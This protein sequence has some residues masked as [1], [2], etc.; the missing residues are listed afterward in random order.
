MSERVNPFANLNEPPPTAPVFTTKPKHSTPVAAEIIGRLSE[1][2]NFPSRQPA[3]PQKEPRRK[4]HVYRTGRNQQFNIKATSETI[5]RFYKMSEEKKVPLG[6]LLKQA[7]DALEGKS[8][9]Q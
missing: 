9:V 4:R 8:P 7:L 5:E 6:E 2:H 1:E 3:K